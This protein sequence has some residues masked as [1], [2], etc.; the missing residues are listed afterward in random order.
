[1]AASGTGLAWRIAAVL[2]AAG[3]VLTTIADAAWA[4]AVGVACL[5]GF[6]AVAFPATATPPQSG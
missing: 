6:V 3:F 4:H 2:L 1:M 5:L